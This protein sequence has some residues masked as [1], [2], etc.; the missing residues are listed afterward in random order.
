[1]TTAKEPV[2][3][4]KMYTGVNFQASS[5]KHSSILIVERGIFPKNEVSL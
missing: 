1:M 2:Q 4:G 5:G 3:N